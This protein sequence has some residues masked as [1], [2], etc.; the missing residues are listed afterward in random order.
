MTDTTD[1]I[2]VEQTAIEQPLSLFE[3]FEQWAEMEPD[4]CQLNGGD[5]CCW[6]SFGAMLGGSLKSITWQEEGEEP[7]TLKTRD[8]AILQASLQE[9][10][11]SHG[12]LYKI[13]NATDGQHYIQILKPGD[14]T[15]FPCQQTEAAI[16]LFHAYLAALKAEP[17]TS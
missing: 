14:N 2:P 1:Q 13:E 17:K 8:F 7:E 9:T 11:A 15:Y 12:W 5:D 3:Q 6:K 10:I 4:R 16:A